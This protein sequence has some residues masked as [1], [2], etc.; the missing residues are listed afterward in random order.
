MELIKKYR[1]IIFFL[2]GY[3]AL[4]VLIIN[5]NVT[6]WGDS[7]RILRA[8]EYLL[9]FSYPLDEKRLPIFSALLAPGLLFIEPVLW[10]RIYAILAAVVNLILTAVLFKQFYPKAK[11]LHLLIVMTL[12]A[13]NPIFFYW[14]LRI[15]AETTFTVF[16]LLA[17][18]VY[19]LDRERFVSRPYVLGVVLS[20][21][22]LT[23]YEGFLLA[24]A[25]GLSYL[26]KKD[27]RSLI[28]TFSVFVLLVAPWFILTKFIFKGGTS[29]AYVSE[30]STFKFDLYRL[31]YFITYSLFFVGSPVL[32]SLLLY[33]HSES[34]TKNLSPLASSAL[35]NNDPSRVV[36]DDGMVWRLLINPLFTFSFLEFALFF[37]W[38]PSLPRIM[39][40]IIPIAI[41]LVVK[42]LVEVD[43]IKQH[44]PF[45]VAA[46]LSVF[47]FL[48]LQLK[49]RL[50]FLVLSYSGL[51]L[52]LALSFLAILTVWRGSKKYF[53]VSVLAT[54]LVGSFVAVANQRLV[55]STIY[56]A[57]VYAKTLPGKIAYSDETGVSAWYLG[58]KG[59]SYPQN[60]QRDAAGQKEWL[61][62]NQISY[63]LDSNE[64]NRGSK[65]DVTG[66]V[67]AY[68]VE[69]TIA[70]VLDSVLI[71]LKIMKP[72]NYTKIYSQLCHV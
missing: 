30:L 5:V 24:G 71:K 70:D 51:A 53:L 18:V 38:T 28:K 45:I 25:F 12:L 11:Q 68:R 61:K 69:E 52:I 46:L 60:L 48:F 16:V 6:E 39:I 54:F 31:G 13:F 27:W 44:R 33:R 14:S 59:V 66:V 1:Y 62:K 20:L 43:F 50:Y 26:L 65:L 19:L 57:S 35:Q 64:F 22:A 8:A 15:M 3:I 7:F 21:A 23:R 17:F 36:Q 58:N 47:C 4:R 40:P 56:E 34:K 55:Y 32:T 29:D 10:G 72:R 67:C 49:F 42:N 37:I 63:V 2:L 9:N 41:I